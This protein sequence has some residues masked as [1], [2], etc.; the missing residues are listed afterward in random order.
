MS[1]IFD[2][3][4]GTETFTADDLIVTRQPK[5]KRRLR[6]MD[7]AKDGLEIWNQCKR[8]AITNIY[9]SDPYVRAEIDAVYGNDSIQTN[10]NDMSFLTKPNAKP[11][12]VD[13]MREIKREINAKYNIKE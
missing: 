3:M 2:E 7:N 10:P 4:D 13:A 9:K 11:K 5:D 8:D 1:N 6:G 12:P